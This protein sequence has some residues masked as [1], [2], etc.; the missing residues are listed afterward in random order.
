MWLPNFGEQMFFGDESVM[1]S[2]E[3][4]IEKIR[5]RFALGVMKTH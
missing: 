5:N 3:S 4:N 2:D 1:I